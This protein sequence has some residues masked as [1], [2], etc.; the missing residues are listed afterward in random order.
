MEFVLALW[1]KAVPY[2]F[3]AG[4]LRIISSLVIRTFMGGRT[5]D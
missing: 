3:M 4:T 1:I 2:I 5:L